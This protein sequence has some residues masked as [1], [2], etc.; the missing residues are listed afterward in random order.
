MMGGNE[1]KEFGVCWGTDSIPVIEGNHA[2]ADFGVADWFTCDITGLTPHTTYNIRAYAVAKDRVYYGNK[3]SFVTRSNNSDSALVPTLNTLA[4]NVVDSSLAYCTAEVLD[5]GGAPILERGVCWGYDEEPTIEH[6]SVADPVADTGSFECMMDGLKPNSVFFVRA[7]AKNSAGIGYG[8]ELGFI[9]TGGNGTTP[10]IPAGFS[11]SENTRVF[12]S[13]GNLQYQASTNTWRFAECQWDYVGDGNTNIS[14]T[15]DGWID[16]FGWGTSGFDHGAVCYQPWST[17]LGRDDYYAYGLGLVSL[18]YGNGDGTADWG[19]NSISNA[20]DTSMR[21]RTLT[22]DEWKYLFKFRD[23]PSGVRYAKAVVN[24]VNGL[25][26]LPDQWSTDYFPLNHVNESEAHFADNTISAE[27]WSVLEQY[28]AVF[29]PAAG[30]RRETS[31]FEPGLFGGYWSATA[32]DSYDA[33]RMYF[34]DDI[35]AVEDGYRRCMGYSV[36]LVTKVSHHSENQAKE[37]FLKKT[38]K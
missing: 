17:S 33:R 11:V 36:R 35:V 38:L 27:R 9:T 31:V 1:I 14:E 4:V 37:N 15:Y 7:Y 2:E 16:L 28:G 12:F 20:P 3:V 8:N 21:W 5:D 26:L 18:D 29:F 6:F 32:L 34:S 23:T 24:Q 10:V 30:R 19:A 13:G 22:W 25:I